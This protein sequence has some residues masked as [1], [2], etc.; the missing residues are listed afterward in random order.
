MND[1]AHLYFTSHRAVSRGR[2]D[3]Y[4]IAYSIGK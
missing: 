4:R 1:P 2:A 3:I